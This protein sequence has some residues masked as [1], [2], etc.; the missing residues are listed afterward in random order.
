[1]TAYAGREL[2]G[3]GL[4]APPS[5]D[6]R[7]PLMGIMDQPFWRPLVGGVRGRETRAQ[8]RPKS[9]NH[10]PCPSTGGMYRLNKRA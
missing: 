6:R 5:G 4:P 9:P 10:N 1:M 8:R 2:P 7:S 3:A